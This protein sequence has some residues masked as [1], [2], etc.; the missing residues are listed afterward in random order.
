MTAPPKANGITAAVRPF[1]S[2]RHVI[3]PSVS[4]SRRSIGLSRC[5]TRKDR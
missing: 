5:W 2:W 1:T 4:T 3:A